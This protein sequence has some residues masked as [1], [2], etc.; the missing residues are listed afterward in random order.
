MPSYEQA[1]KELEEDLEAG[2]ITYE[3]FLRFQKE[4]NAEFPEG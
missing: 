1:I 3:E 4:L 2:R